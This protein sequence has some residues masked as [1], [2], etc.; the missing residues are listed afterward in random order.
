MG[1]A[2]LETNRG[3]D[4]NRETKQDAPSWVD[5]GICGTDDIEQTTFSDCPA[6]RAYDGDDLKCRE[7][8]ATSSITVEHDAGQDVAEAGDWTPAPPKAKPHPNAC[9]KGD[10]HKPYKTCPHC[11]RYEERT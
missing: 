3:E 7:C 4:M 8:G 5:C 9:P 10:T 6:E 1:W 2:Y 11:S